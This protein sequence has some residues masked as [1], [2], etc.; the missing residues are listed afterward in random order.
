MTLVSTPR[1]EDRATIT[2]R[3]INSSAMHRAESEA[4]I[5]ALLNLGGLAFYRLP[6]KWR[7]VRGL[8][9]RK[10]MPSTRLP[11]AI[12]EETV[13]GT[14]RICRQFSSTRWLST[15]AT[16]IRPHS[17]PYNPT[18]TLEIWS[19][20]KVFLHHYSSIA[21]KRWSLPWPK[22]FEAIIANWY[23]KMIKALILLSLTPFFVSGINVPYSHSL[24]RRDTRRVLVPP[25]LM[26]RGSDLIAR[27]D[28]C[29]GVACDSGECCEGS[30]WYEF[31]VLCW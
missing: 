20:V 26:E 7:V 30:C 19:R 10:S 2:S 16:N 4:N 5:N 8:R 31:R 29:I 25:T 22:N 18:G 27:Q 14:V 3:L 6:S 12:N 9:D 23:H 11:Y 17:R 1:M 24:V 13:W 15:I 28:I 21:V